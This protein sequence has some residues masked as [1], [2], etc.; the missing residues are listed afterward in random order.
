VS[1]EVKKVKGTVKWYS[2]LKGYGF[3]TG[4]DEKDVF[5]HHE[6]IPQGIHIHEG[7]QVE[8]QIHDTDR[9]PKAVELKKL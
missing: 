3:I 7:D 9:G 8:Y 6:G 4:N 1:E 5:V 2:S